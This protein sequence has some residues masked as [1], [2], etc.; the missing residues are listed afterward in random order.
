MWLSWEEGEWNI[1][2]WNRN[3][4][5][6]KQFSHGGYGPAEILIEPELTKFT[7]KDDDDDDDDGDDDDDD[8]TKPYKFRPSHYKHGQCFERSVSSTQD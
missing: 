2:E 1:V 3:G 8:A 7:S 4:S 5:G 6:P